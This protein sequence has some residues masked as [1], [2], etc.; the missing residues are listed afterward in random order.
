MTD[1]TAE[2]VKLTELFDPQLKAKSLHRDNGNGTGI[3]NG[4]EEPGLSL[5]EFMRV[6]LKIATLMQGNEELV[7]KMETL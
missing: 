6:S 5:S 7:Q 3:G 2:L 1:R 4:Y